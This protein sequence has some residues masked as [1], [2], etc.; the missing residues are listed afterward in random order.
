MVAPTSTSML[1]GRNITLLNI[2]NAIQE[3]IVRLVV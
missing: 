1:N 2:S 3:T